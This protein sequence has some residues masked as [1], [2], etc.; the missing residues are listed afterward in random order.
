MFAE[1]DIVSLFILSAKLLHKDVFLLGNL[2]FTFF[3]CIIY[4]LYSDFRGHIIMLCQ[5]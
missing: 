5:K 3:F 4:Y 1:W 2:K